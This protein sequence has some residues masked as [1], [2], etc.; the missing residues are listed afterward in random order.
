LATLSVLVQDEVPEGR[1]GQIPAG[2]RTHDLHGLRGDAC[3]SDIESSVMVTSSTIVSNV[4]CRLNH[5]FSKVA[6]I[7][8]TRLTYTKRKHP[9]TA[10]VDE[11]SK[12]ATM[13]W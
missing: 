5:C 2:T 13:I 10:S 1:C 4:N 12:R 6:S 8:N 3:K 11:L 9:Q 7:S